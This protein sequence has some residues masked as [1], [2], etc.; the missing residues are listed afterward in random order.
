MLILAAAAISKITAQRLD[1]FWRG[2][3]DAQ[4]PGPGETLFHLDHFGFH[5]FA[6]DHKRHENNEIFEPRHAFAAECNVAYRQRQS[7]ADSQTQD[8]SLRKPAPIQ[9]QIFR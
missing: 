1:S 4:E 7:I 8:S 3:N 9:K 6:N 5:D 2:L